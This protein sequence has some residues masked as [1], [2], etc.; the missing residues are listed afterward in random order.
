MNWG[1]SPA[2]VVVAWCWL[3]QRQRLTLEA[4]LTAKLIE[5]RTSELQRL[6]K[7]F[8]DGIKIDSM[9]SALT[10]LST[11]D[12]IEALAGGQRDPV[13]LADLARGVMRKKIPD[14]TLALRG[15]VR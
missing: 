5:Q 8:E 10:T 3:S 9:A 14:L 7:V 4:H 11:R 6:A 2:D 13:V 1:A 12:M 15:S